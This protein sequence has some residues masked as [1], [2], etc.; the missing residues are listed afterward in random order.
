MHH[1]AK[2]AK[3][4]KIFKPCKPAWQRWLGCKWVDWIGWYPGWMRYRASYSVKNLW[5]KIEMVCSSQERKGLAT[6]GLSKWKFGVEI[7]VLMYT[8]NISTTKLFIS[9]WKVQGGKKRFNWIIQKYRLSVNSESRCSNPS[10]SCLYPSVVT[11]HLVSSKSKWVGEA[12][13]ISPSFLAI[14]QIQNKRE[15]LMDDTFLPSRQVQVAWSAFSCAELAQVQWVF[16][17]LPKL[18]DLKSSCRS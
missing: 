4:C 2:C 3:L 16:A 1:C 11:Y 5:C 12:D 15:L 17:E 9:S 13:Y 7:K 8:W 14:K 10:S 6:V 18:C